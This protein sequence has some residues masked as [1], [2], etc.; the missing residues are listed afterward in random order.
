[1]LDRAIVSTIYITAK[2]E[3]PM[4]NGGDAHHVKKWFKARQHNGN[5]DLL[6]HV[7]VSLCF[8]TIDPVERR[9]STPIMCHW[10]SA[11]NDL[12]LIGR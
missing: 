8:G 5:Y 1:M 7:F 12:R 11:T 6:L 10:D 9:G 4:A 2:H 3:W